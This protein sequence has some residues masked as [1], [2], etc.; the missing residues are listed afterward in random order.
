ML[1]K[2]YEIQFFVNKVLVQLKT[3]FSKASI[4]ALLD[5]NRFYVLVFSVLVSIFAACFLGLQTEG[6]L[7]YIQLE[8][9]YGFIALATLYVTLIISP[10]QKV[11]GKPAWMENVIFA[12]RATGVAVVYFALLH[13]GVALWGELGGLEGLGLLPE[14]F[15]WPLIFSATSLVILVFLAVISVDKM[16]IML[17]YHR[18]KWFQR[19]VYLCGILIIFHVWAIGIHFT[20]GL[21]R[22]IC[23]VALVILFGLESWRMVDFLVERYHWRTFVKYLLFVVMWAVSVLLLAWV[24][25]SRPAEAHTLV[26]DS[27]AKSGAILHVTPDDDPIAGQSTSLMLD[28]QDASLS[29]SQL[30]ASLTVIDDINREIKVPARIHGKAIAADYTFPRQG[31]Y[32]LVFST[33]QGGQQTLSFTESLRVSRGAINEA[34]IATSIP[35]WAGLGVLGSVIAMTVMGVIAFIRRKTIGIYS[36]L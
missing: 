10:I 35:L 27:Q 9:V 30:I 21:I 15:V 19:L 23:L 22:D 32:T 36:K 26:K 8:Q 14:K 2:N 20:P 1:L 7:Y 5:N 17:G 31:L 28:V 29:N 33:Q 16:V 24:S 18:W 4:K 6:D 34:A 11:V 13:A 25:F 3:M 12:R